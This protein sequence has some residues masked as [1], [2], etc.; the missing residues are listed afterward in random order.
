LKRI[1]CSVYFEYLPTG[2]NISINKDAEFFPAS[3]LKV[4]VAMAIAKK[5]DKREWDGIINWF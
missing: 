4:P 2:A 5:I 1:P 3:L